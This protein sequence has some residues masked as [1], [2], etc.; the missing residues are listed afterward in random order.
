MMKYHT[1]LTHWLHESPLAPYADAFSEYLSLNNYSA[2]TVSHYN[3]CFAHFSYWINTNDIDIHKINEGVIKHFLDEY[4]SCCI[5]KHKIC[6]D[7]YHNFH[8][9]LNHILIVLRVNSIISF[10]SAIK[11][12]V[13]KELKSFDDYMN[14][15]RGLAPRTRHEY[16]RIIQRLLFER[17]SNHSVVISMFKPDDVRQFIFNQKNLYTTQSS[18][19]L[20]ISALRG[21]FRFRKTCGDQVNHL[22]G[23][24]NFPANWQLSSLPKT[25]NHDEIEC[26]L[27]AIEHDS[28]SD[29]RMKAMV[30]C[31]LDLGLRSCEVA[32]LGLDDIDWS[33][34]A[35]ILKK[36]KSRRVDTLPLPEATGHALADYLKFERPKNL[37]NRAVFIRHYAPFEKPVDPNIVRQTIHKAYALAGLPYSRSYLLR[38]TM[39]SRLLETGSSLK[40]IADVLRHRSL[41]TTMIYAKLDS[42]NLVEVALPWPG[43]TS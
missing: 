26:L 16:L 9:A 3:R 40:E 17:F 8:A 32:N 15:V 19:G 22:V 7:E 25:L 41:N 11:S 30:H 23:V 12:P 43:R 5:S 4:F 33:N 38:H 21:Y 34:A 36:T 27:K 29:L 10:P 13:D 2:S 28:Q 31:A 14:D 18:T 20:L 24:T 1:K 42:R 39:A 37:R 6:S 35:I